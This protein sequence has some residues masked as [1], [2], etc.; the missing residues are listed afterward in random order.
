[1]RTLISNG[2][3]VTADG[4]YAADIL[5][6]GEKIAGIGAGLAQM[7]NATADETIDATGKYVI[8]GGIDV[9]THMQLPF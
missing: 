9:H 6:D 3:V 7:A 2:T 8:P 4:S 1:M 5:V